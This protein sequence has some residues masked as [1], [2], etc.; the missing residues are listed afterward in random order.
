MDIKSEIERLREEIRG[1]DAAYYDNDAPLIEDYE[2][3]ELKHR[4]ADL[5]AEYPQY[6]SEE[7]PTMRVGGTA[8]AA[9]APVTHNVPLKS[10]VDVFS[11]GEAE[12]FIER[13]SVSGTS[14][15]SVE[16]KIDGLSVALYYADGKLQIGATRGDGTTG[17]DVTH[18][19]LTIKNIPQTIEFS[20]AISVRGEVYMPKSV[21]N[22]LNTE[23]ELNGETLFANPRNAAAGSLRQLDAG[24]CAK[25]QLSF[26]A[27]NVQSIDG[28]AFETHKQSLEFLK[29]LGFETVPSAIVTTAGQAAGEIERIDK[30]RDNYAYDIDGAVV[31]I[32]DLS[33][34]ETLG[35]TAK[36]P[37]WA[38]A[39]KYPPEERETEL[40]D[41]MIQ[42][43]RTG[44][45]TPKA[46]VKPVRLSGS[47]VSFATLHNS[48]FISSRDIRIGDTI[49]IR[50]AGEIIPE[51]LSVNLDKRPK[52]A[53]PFAFPEI[54]PVCG[55]AVTRDEGAAAV[56]CVN[57][58][59]S[60][61]IIRNVEHFVSRKAMDIEGCGQAVAKQLFDAGLIKSVADLYNLTA[62][63]IG[64]LDRFAKKSAEKLA[65]NIEKSKSRG[66]TAVLYGLGIPQVGESAAKA[67][68]KTFGSIDKLMAADIST[69]TAITDIGEITA[70]MITDWFK[71]PESMRVID[72]LREAGVDMTA[73]IKEAPK[74]GAFAGLTVVLTGALS[75]YTRDE[76]SEIIEKLGGKT[77]GSVS[78]KTSLVIAGEDAGSKLTKAQSLGVRV[79][80]EAEFEEMVK[81]KI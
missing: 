74:D 25:R 53:V 29:D 4:L 59:C 49:R 62:E 32:N 16:P 22:A 63:Q 1:Y 11:I 44:V 38:I 10:L 7:S 68:A 48:D 30:S 45:L 52:E 69:L 39:Y 17:E 27:F 31:K 46:A 3:D 55:S 71:K 78:K 6:K 66:L 41:I 40:L 28:K 24:V 47:T 8:S 19:I 42:V 23:R 13:T 20:S 81:T 15:Y 37:R 73:E 76:A 14:A 64:A 9:F 75:N 58:E 77:S 60:A 33:L 56:R 21:F 51:V 54:C 70:G 80:T 26:V 43:G 67:L 65:A 2:Y 36:A 5:E 12:A 72:R 18:N 57:P 34:R 79:I 50:K 61:Q 35:E